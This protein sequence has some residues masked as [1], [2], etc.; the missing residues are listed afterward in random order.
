[1]SGAH[2]PLQMNFTEYASHSGALDLSPT[3][4]A[5]LTETG[6]HV[7]RIAFEQEPELTRNFLFGVIISRMAPTESACTDTACDPACSCASISCD[8]IDPKCCV[9]VCYELCDDFPLCEGS[10]E[11]VRLQET[12]Q[13]IL[14]VSVRLLPST[15]FQRSIGHY[16][17]IQPV[18]TAGGFRGVFRHNPGSFLDVKMHAVL[19]RWQRGPF[20]CPGEFKAPVTLVGVLPRNEWNAYFKTIANVLWYHAYVYEI[21]GEDVSAGFSL[22]NVKRTQESLSSKKDPNLHGKLALLDILRLVYKHNYEE[23]NQD[24]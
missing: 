22:S 7:F 19:A 15:L 2:L 13:R 8:T 12:M 5:L 14:G 11:Y 23:K 21:I 16:P 9:F 3:L 4:R 20:V 24:Q 1:M 18:F 6:E 17:A 10:A